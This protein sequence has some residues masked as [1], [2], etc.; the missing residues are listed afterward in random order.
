MRNTMYLLQLLENA[1]ETQA[2]YKFSSFKDLV[3]DV[4]Q[5]LNRWVTLS[6]VG[7][8]QD[9][10]EPFRSTYVFEYFLV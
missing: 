3:C 5:T 9:V 2:I 1:H 6:R 8:S 4:F 7:T 10:P